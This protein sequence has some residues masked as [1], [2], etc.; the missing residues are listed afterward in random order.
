MSFVLRSWICLN[1]DCAADFDSGDAAPEC[2]KCRNVK[3][4]WRPAGGHIMS[5]ATKH[6]DRTV[7]SLAASFGLSNLNSARQGEAAHPGVPQGKPLEGMRYGAY[8]GIPLATTCTAGFAPNPPNIKIA[9]P[10]DGAKRFRKNG[11]IPTAIKAV[12]PR[13]I[14]L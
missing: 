14:T 13:R 2:P 12:D 5:A 6:N 4:Q 3:V 9:G 1:D 10:T 11:K 7:K 8:G